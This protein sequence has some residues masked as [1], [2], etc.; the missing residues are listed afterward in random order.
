MTMFRWFDL[1]KEPYGIRETRL[2]GRQEISL[3][4]LTN[5]KTSHK[6]I[7]NQAT[8]LHAVHGI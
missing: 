4:H 7:P 1:N 3:R 8:G 2:N 6:A 5:S